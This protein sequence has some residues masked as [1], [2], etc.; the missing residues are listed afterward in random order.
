MR[1]RTGPE[2]RLPRRS[3]SRPGPRAGR[4]GR[5]GRRPR[6]VHDPAAGRRPGSPCPGSRTGRVIVVTSAVDTAE[7]RTAGPIDLTVVR[8]EVERVAEEFLAAKAATAAGCGHPPEVVRILRDFLASGGK[9]VRPLLCVVGWYAAGGRGDMTAVLRAAASLEL[10]QTFV[11]IHDDIID[12]SAVRRGRPAVH[13][14]LAA[15]HSRLESAARL[16][17]GGALLAGNLALIWSQELL[18]T[19]GL[20]AERLRAVHR[21]NDAMLA[22]VMFGQYRDLLGA[23]RVDDDVES[24]LGIIRYKTAAGTIQRPLQLGVAVGGGGQTALEFCTAFGVPLGEAFQLRDDLLDVYGSADGSSD[25]GLN[26]LREGKHTV[27]MALAM[28]SATAAQRVRLRALVGRAD[29]D[30]GGAAEIRGVLGSTG[31]RDAVEQMISARYHQCLGVLDAAPLPPAAATALREL[32]V[33]A[34]QYTA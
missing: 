31:A 23:E 2:A 17:A 26:D 20:P 1:H 24:A 14:A 6:D 15:R 28:R 5:G 19:L 8:D 33:T 21:V 4:G 3:P 25:P 13:R 32:A 9:R 12:D 16:G 7:A 10:Y 11:L 22:E 30:E 29:L 27:L 34:T 18:H